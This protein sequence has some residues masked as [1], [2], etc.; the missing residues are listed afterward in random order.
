MKTDVWVF[1][2]LQFYFCIFV[3]SISSKTKR[4]G[5]EWPLTSVYCR[6]QEWA[7]QYLRENR[8]NYFFY[9]YKTQKTFSFHV[10]QLDE[11]FEVKHKEI[12]E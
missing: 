6:S 12:L 10:L 5:P 4:P 7:E 11:C 2:V 9:L 3:S 8:D 1:T